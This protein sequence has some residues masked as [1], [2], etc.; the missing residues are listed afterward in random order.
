MTLLIFVGPFG[1]YIGAIGPIVVVGS[2][3][4]VCFVVMAQVMY[5]TLFAVYAW[6]SKADHDYNIEP[7]FDRFSSSYC[8]ILLFIALVI[9]CNKK[10]ISIFMRMT[11]FGVI[12]VTLLMLSIFVTGIMSLVNTS[13]PVQVTQ[14]SFKQDWSADERTLSL[15]NMQFAPLVGILCAGFYLHSLGIPI[16][17]NS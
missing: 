3:I 13:F 15:F 4:I 11:S 12:G 2:A 5:P 1:Y 10:D 7:A 9:I 6:I 17:R 14:I 16:A 8:A